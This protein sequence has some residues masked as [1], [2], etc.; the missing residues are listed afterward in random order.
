MHRLAA[1]VRGKCVGIAR[2][3]VSRHRSPVADVAIAVADA[4]QRQ[5]LGRRLV[6]ALVIEARACGIRGF[7]ATMH[8]ANDAAR[9]LARAVAATTSYAE[10][11]VAA[12]LTIA[13]DA[14]A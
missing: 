9:G 3:V 8:P 6:N 14:A 2:A 1:R 7:E 13:H 5:G 4:H 11:E 12:Q 10:G